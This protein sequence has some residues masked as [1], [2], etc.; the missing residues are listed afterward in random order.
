VPQLTQ[1]R[2]LVRSDKRSSFHYLVTLRNLAAHYCS[3]QKGVPVFEW[4]DGKDETELVLCKNGTR[5][6]IS[7]LGTACVD[8][9]AEA[10][11]LMSVCTFGAHLPDLRSA[12]GKAEQRA[13]HTIGFTAFTD[14]S[15]VAQN[16][17]YG[18]ATLRGTRADGCLC[19]ISLFLVFG[20]FLF[21]F[22]LH[23]CAAK[24]IV[25]GLW[26]QDSVRSLLRSSDELLRLI[27][28]L[29][30]VLGGPGAARVPE[31]RRLTYV[32]TSDQLRSLYL[33]RA[34]TCNPA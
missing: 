1:Y 32:N 3:G 27:F 8:M 2:P 4:V 33:T 14:V 10:K 28:T 31:L 13:D 24:Y 15:S 19:V 23:G 5:C 17:L 21:S 26:K 20:N 11:R 34:G 12:F 7:L 22:H 25:N 16:A 18:D 29:V 30:H 9:I 6:S